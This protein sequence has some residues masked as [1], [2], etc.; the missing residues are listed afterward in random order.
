MDELQDH[1]RRFNR[2]ERFLLVGQALGN[3]SF[4]LGEEFASGLSLCLHREVPASAYCAMD[5]HLDWLFAAL[6]WMYGGIDV[7]NAVAREFNDFNPKTGGSADLKVTGNQS[8]VD[9]LIA[10]IDERGRGQLVL[11]EAKGYSPWDPE[12][13]SYK[14]A[15]LNAIFGFEGRRFAGVDAH[16]VLSGPPPGPT[17]KALPKAQ[18][19]KWA[20]VNDATDAPIKYFLPLHKPGYETFAVERITGPTQGPRQPAANGSHWQIKRA[21]WPSTEDAAPH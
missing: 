19:P 4:T 6:V 1:L 20:R 12:Q 9:L 16:L 2:K 8:D 7:G 21:Q 5:Y 13:M 3:T 10:W 15:R 17:K 11:I 14:C 18:W